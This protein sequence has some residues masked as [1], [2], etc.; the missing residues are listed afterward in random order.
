MSEFEKEWQRRFERFGTHHEAEHLVSGWSLVGLRR[1]VALFEH[2]LDGGLLRPGARVLELGCGAGT[3][4]RLLG[5]RGHPVVG[6][7][8]SL[9]TLSRA[10]AADPGRLGRYVAGAAHA[11]P[12]ASEAFDGVICIG[13]LQ[14]LERPDPAM[15]EMVR[16][17]TPGGVV[18]AETLNPWDPLAAARRLVALRHGH[19]TKLRYASPGRLE[20]A[21][22]EHGLRAGERIGIVLPPKSLT[23]VADV[24]GQPWFQRLLRYVPGANAVASHAF[25]LVGRRL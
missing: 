22:A 16:V 25:W 12:F 5:K 11:L 10:S 3:Y 7:D 18:L 8:Y 2:L 1:R 14:A 24:L 23:G 6:L 21:M 17:V 20:R 13:V 19:P 15:A 9:P 4:V